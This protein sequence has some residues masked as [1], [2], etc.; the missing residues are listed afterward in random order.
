M[1]NVK[2]VIGMGATVF[3]WTDRSAGTIERVSASGKRIWI[4]QD[5]ATRIDKNGMSDCQEYSYA[6]NPQGTLYEASLRKNGRWIL[7]GGKD[8]VVGI[9]FRRAYHDYSF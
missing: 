3:H 7:K 8:T 2:P 1:D 6:A 5:T 9:D 4:R